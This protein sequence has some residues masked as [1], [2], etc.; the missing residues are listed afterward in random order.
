MRGSSA[1][2]LE[3]RR[4]HPR[5][6]RC[7]PLRSTI[8]NSDARSPV[9]LRRPR[10]ARASKDGGS[11]AA[12]VAL[13]GSLRSH[14]RVTGKTQ[15]IPFSRCGFASELLFQTAR[16][17]ASNGREAFISA[18]PSKGSG[19]PTG[20]SFLGR[21]QRHGSGSS[22]SRSPLGA[23]LRRLPR[24]LMPWLSPGRASRETECEGVTSALNRAYSDAPRAPVIV[25]AGRCPSRPGAGVTSPRPQEPHPAPS[26]G[27][28]G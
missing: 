17:F 22:V 7:L 10:E 3:I 12:A 14:L 28:T 20:A 26:V 13:R 19:A 21:A 24:K 11:N 5:D 9:I 15:A 23:P 16:N 4:A 1:G 27:V 2:C 18:S 6:L 8:S 25:P